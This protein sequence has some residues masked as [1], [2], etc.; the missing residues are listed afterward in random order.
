MYGPT[1]DIILV[2]Y[3]SF[4]AG[5]EYQVKGIIDH[6]IVSRTF[7]YYISISQEVSWSSTVQIYV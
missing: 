6:H 3:H 7:P 1:H 5:R 2:D 4:R